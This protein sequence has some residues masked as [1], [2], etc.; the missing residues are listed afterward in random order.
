LA[1]I[2]EELTARAAAIIGAT[3]AP[4]NPAAQPLLD[5]LLRIV[6]SSPERGGQS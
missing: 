2:V 6:G 1:K 4:D 5:L 3:I